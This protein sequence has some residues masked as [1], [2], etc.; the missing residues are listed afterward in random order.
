VNSLRRG[1]DRI[2]LALPLPNVNPNVVSGLSIVTSMLFVVSF[3]FFSFAA[4]VFLFMTILLDWFDGLIAKKFRRMSEE[5][6]IVDVTSDRL[7]EGIIFSAVFFPWFFLFVLNCLL[8]IRSVAKKRH[9]VLPLRH[10]FLIYLIL[11]ILV[12]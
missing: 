1:T 10:L 2:G 6:Y 4:V 11:L 8:T 7:S 12:Q 5:G 3:P 9:I